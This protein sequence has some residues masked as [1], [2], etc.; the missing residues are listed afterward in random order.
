MASDPTDVRGDSGMPVADSVQSAPPVSMQRRPKNTQKHMSEAEIEAFVCRNIANTARCCGDGCLFKQPQYAKYNRGV[1]MDNL[2]YAGT[3]IQHCRNRTKGMDREQKMETLRRDLQ[4]GF[5]GITPGGYGSVEPRLIPEGPIVCRLA[6]QHAHNITESAYRKLFTLLKDGVTQYAPPYNDS[7]VVHPEIIVA[8]NEVGQSFNITLTHQQ[9]SAMVLPKA[10]GSLHLYCW[11]EEFFGFVGEHMP[12]SNEIHL[13]NAT[14]KLTVH[15][16]YKT[17]CLAFQMSPL[18]YNRFLE[19]W[20]LCFPYVK[21]REYK[22]V[23]G[24]CWTCLTLSEARNKFSDRIRSKIVRELHALHRAA[25]MSERIEY[26]KRIQRSIRDPDTFMSLIADGMAQIHCQLPWFNN[27][28][29]FGSYL[30]QHLQGCFQHGFSFS[31]YRTFHN[32]RNSTNLNIYCMLKEIERRFR[33]C[34]LRENESVLSQSGPSETACSGNATVAESAVAD[35]C[36]DLLPQ[37]RPTTLDL[38]LDGGPENKSKVFLAF[39]ALLVAR[40]LFTQVRVTR[41]P[42]GHTHEDIDSIFALIWQKVKRSFCFTPNDYEALIRDATRSKGKKQF[43]EDV[44]MVPDFVRFLT[45][46]VDSGF[47]H[48]AVEQYTQHVWIFDAVDIDARHPNGVH[49][50]FRKYSSPNFTELR[51]DTSPESLI[52]L[53]PV[54]VEPLA[55][56]AEN[57]GFINILREMPSGEIHPEGFIE[58]GRKVFE[59]YRN[60]MRRKYPRA[61]DKMADLNAFEAIVPSSDSATDYFQRVGG[62]RIPFHRLLFGGAPL[63]PQANVLR[64]KVRNC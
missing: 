42:V 33:D 48:F 50:H 32:V 30:P 20:C 3:I 14:V 55:F 59:A 60:K 37:N 11:L 52:G 29:D 28:C 34:L 23:T 46:F 35:Q 8:T 44:F 51:L 27:Q 2:T 17:E 21:I 36:D 31:C 64:K 22:G 38:Q 26:Y 43:V 47:S 25:Y 49:T 45:P 18:S 9:R 13:D 63:N 24:K 16:L 39:C 5:R 10:E 7:S 12:N 15:K 53:Q 56:P 57:E 54:N 40:R 19:I 61:A 41:L 4:G 62:L 6:Y 58:G 1:E